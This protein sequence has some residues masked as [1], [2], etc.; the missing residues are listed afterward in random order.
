MDIRQALLWLV[1]VTLTHFLFL[2]QIPSLLAT[3]TPTATNQLS[4]VAATCEAERTRRRRRTRGHLAAEI[5]GRRLTEGVI[6]GL[7][8]KE[9][10]WHFRFTQT[11]LLELPPEIVTPSGY[12]FTRTEAFALTCARLRTPADL[13]DLASHYNQLL[14]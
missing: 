3:S 7:S 8:D 5:G 6:R 2:Q 9:C 12:R 1:P 4:T 13:D 14:L 11:E 10:L